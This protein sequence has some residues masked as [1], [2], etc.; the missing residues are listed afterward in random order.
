ME[1]T[2]EESEGNKTVTIEKSLYE[3]FQKFV[4][5]RC[6]FDWIKWPSHGQDGTAY[7]FALMFDH[8]SEEYQEKKV[9]MEESEHEESG[10]GR[11][12]T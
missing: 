10:H 4:A 8:D 9:D 5:I 11:K 1:F 12:W 3:D 2:I 7:V 6:R